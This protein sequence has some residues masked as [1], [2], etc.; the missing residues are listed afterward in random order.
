MQQR[1][2]SD[3]CYFSATFPAR[4]WSGQGGLLIHPTLTPCLTNPNPVLQKFWHGRRTRQKGVPSPSRAKHRFFGNPGL[5]SSGNRRSTALF[6]P[7]QMTVPLFNAPRCSGKI[8]SCSKKRVEQ[9]CRKPG[10]QAVILQKTKLNVRKGPVLVPGDGVKQ[11]VADSAV[12][13]HFGLPLPPFIAEST[14]FNHPFG[15][16]I[17][18]IMVG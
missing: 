3:S 15:T 5:F 16:V 1:L 6:C 14:F 13:Q 17:I 7:L 8:R 11:F 4:C 2:S 18:R 12:E 9:R 10:Q